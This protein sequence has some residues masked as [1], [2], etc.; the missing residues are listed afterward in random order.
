M[1]H[2]GYDLV[3][4]SGSSF[5][6]GSE[7]SLA[8][9]GKRWPRHEIF[10]YPQLLIRK[11][12]GLEEYSFGSLALELSTSFHMAKCRGQIFHILY[13]EHFCR[14]TPYLNGWRENLVVATFHETA[15]Q[16]EQ[17]LHSTSHL[18]R[19]A[20]IVIL[21]ENQR[22][23]FERFVPSERIWFVP[24]GVDTTYF[25]PRQ[26]RLH[27]EQPLCVSIGGHLR[28]LETLARAIQITHDRGVRVRY[29]IVARRAQAAAVRGLPDVR[30][31]DFVTDEEM[32]R[33]YQE[34]DIMVTPYED[35]VASNVLL[36]GMACA[37]PL[38]VTD[39]GAVRD[40]LDDSAAVLVP[41]MNPEALAV[42][43]QTLA[44][45]PSRRGQIGQRARQLAEELDHTKV[46]ARL[47]E[48][49]WVVAKSQR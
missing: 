35:V 23:F 36:E 2:S 30:V 44:E 24:H 28:D 9:Q 20:A 39:V 19:L 1:A 33:L 5:T 32:L 6:E 47:A 3:A 18:K 49:Y 22:A 40:Y 11:L 4:S 26:H 29:D 17:R 8:D 16:L 46:A 7:I 42:G 15:W 43:I 38:V 45:D 13:G 48:L 34:A 12:S 27:R 10:R 31:R 25:V 21:G 41:P 14:F 37:A